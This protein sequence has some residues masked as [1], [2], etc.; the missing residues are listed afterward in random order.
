MFSLWESVHAHKEHVFSNVFFC[1][2]NTDNSI[3]VTKPSFEKMTQIKWAKQEAKAM[4]FLKS[5]HSENIA[6]AIK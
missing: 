6:Q 4:Y 5:Y 1:G 3:K 2:S